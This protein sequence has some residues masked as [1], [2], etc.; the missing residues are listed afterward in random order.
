MLELPGTAV[1]KMNH[2]VSNLSDVNLTINV[3]DLH[4]HFSYSYRVYRFTVFF[5]LSP[6]VASEPWIFFVSKEA[7]AAAELRQRA[8]ESEAPG[9]CWEDTATRLR[10]G[11]VG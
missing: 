2:I 9:V 1:R 8:Q 3:G 4:Q 10:L 7:A 5:T 6:L 11:V